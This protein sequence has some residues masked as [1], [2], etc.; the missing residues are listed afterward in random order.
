MQALKTFLAWL[1]G[2]KS[3]IAGVITTTSAFLAFKG[4]I[5]TEDAAFINALSL[6]F[7][8]TASVATGKLVYPKE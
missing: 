8:G 5:S 6:I 4:I 7:F 1:S 2:K 3:I